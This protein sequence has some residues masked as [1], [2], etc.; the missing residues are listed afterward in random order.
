L[1]P[2]QI[3]EDSINLLKEYTDSGGILMPDIAKGDSSL[4]QDEI[5]NLLSS[6][7]QKDVRRVNI[8]LYT[9]NKRILD[10]KKGGRFLVLSEKFYMFEGWKVIA[11]GKSKKIMRANGINSAIYLDGSEKRIELVY[12]PKSFRND[13][14]ISILCVLLVL[15][16]FLVHKKY[17]LP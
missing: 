9:P 10:L 3:D 8:S 7:H 17:K 15:I 11:N 4:R 2:G 6:F 14:F 16:Y 13:V 12:K 1:S 5:N